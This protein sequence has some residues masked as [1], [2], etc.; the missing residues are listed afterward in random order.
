MWRF[1]IS[2]RTQL[3][4]HKAGWRQIQSGH[5]NGRNALKDDWKVNGRQDLQPCSSVCEE[6]KSHSWLDVRDG[7]GPEVRTRSHPPQHRGVRF[8][9]L[10][11]PDW[12]SSLESQ[13]HSWQVIRASRLASCCCMHADQCKVPGENIPRCAKTEL[14]HPVSIHLWRVHP[15]GE[16]RAWETGMG[17]IYDYPVSLSSTLLR[18]RDIVLFWRSSWQGIPR[19]KQCCQHPEV[20][21]VLLWDVSLGTLLF[22]IRCFHP[23]VW[24]CHGC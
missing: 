18:S 14:N 17:T 12:S 16:R 7:R 4:G 2:W 11:Q 21:R 3:K 1:H 20:C 24:H 6:E 23:S 8:L 5:P 15:D 9:L 22:T 13:T 10:Y 19:K